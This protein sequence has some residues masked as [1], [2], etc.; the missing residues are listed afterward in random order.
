MEPVVAL[1]RLSDDGETAKA[2][3]GRSEEQLSFEGP[4]DVGPAVRF[5]A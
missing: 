4:E 5:L 1:R 2:S 3:F